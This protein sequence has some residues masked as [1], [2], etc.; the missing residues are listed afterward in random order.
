L[1]FTAF[2]IDRIEQN[3][4]RRAAA[5]NNQFSICPIRSEILALLVSGANEHLPGSNRAVLP[6]RRSGERRRQMNHIRKAVLIKTTLV[7][8]ILTG[9]TATLCA[10][11]HIATIEGY[12]PDVLAALEIRD[13]ARR[14][15]PREVAGY[16]LQYVFTVANKW[17]G[18]NGHP[19]RITVAFNGGD[20]ALREKIANA[21]AEWSQYGHVEF[22]F[23]ESSTDAFREWS[24]SDTTYRSDIRISF[25]QPG[26]WSM[27]GT[28]SV[29]G[30]ARKPGQP[31]MN[32]SQFTN[33]LPGDW[34]TIVQHEFGHALGLQHEHQAPIGGCDADWKWDDDPGYLPTTDAYGWYGPDL[35]GRSP[36]IYT[37]LAGYPN[38]WPKSIVDQNLRQLNND[39]H[40]YDQSPFDKNSIMKYYFPAFMF[41]EKEQSHCYSE[42]NLRISPEDEVG[43][44]RWYPAPGQALLT[45]QNVQRAIFSQLV[46]LKEIEPSAKQSLQIQLNKLTVQ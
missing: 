16:S 23:K 42:E 1:T 17:S 29:D 28:D 8:A 13:R 34:K 24:P 2:P 26:Y 41:R 19:P 33:R 6:K 22:D 3:E 21:A 18:T 4:F 25:D 43:I 14:N 37:F 27:V 36:G 15:A 11:Q 44:E 38:Y 45:L 32:F 5:F 9:F 7:M 40:A 35:N 12:P 46:Q 10:Q 39:V 31:S 20:N 30:I